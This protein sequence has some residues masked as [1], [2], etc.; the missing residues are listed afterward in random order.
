MPATDYGQITSITRRLFMPKLVDNILDNSF[1]L[2]RLLDKAKTEKGGTKIVQPVKYAKNTASGS[3]SGL[4]TFATNQVQTR[5]AFEFDWKQYYISI[6]LDGMSKAKNAGQSKVIDHVKTSMEEASTDLRDA[7]STDLYQ[8]G[9]G[10]S[11][12]EMTGLVAAVDDGT[13]VAAYG[14]ITRSAD[15]WAKANYTASIGSLALDDLATMYDSCKSGVEVPTV[16]VT[17]EA[18][19]SV[20]EAL[21]TPTVRHNANMDGYPKL[22]RS[23]S[24]ERGASQ[25]FNSLFFRGTPVV[26]DEYC[27]SGYIYFLNENFLDFKILPNAKYK[28]DKHGFAITDFKEP[29]NQDGEVAQVLWY[30]NLVCSQ[31]RRQGVLRGVTA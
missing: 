26:A 6:V 24:P 23:G 18:V 16:L 21:L 4:D 19:W 22:G 5:T 13:N 28:S 9:T 1:L 25:G 17:T 10:N 20:Y 29:T 30:G 3:Y 12:K 15:V 14:G 7:M 27:T 2:G 11:S 31:P 8:D